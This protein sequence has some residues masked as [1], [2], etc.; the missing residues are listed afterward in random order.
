MRIFLFILC[1]LSFLAGS[2]IF[3]GA[4]SAIHEIE[5]FLLFLICAVFSVGAAI[6]DAIHSQ[7]IRVTRYLDQMFQSQQKAEE[8]LRILRYASQEQTKRE[9]SLPPPLTLDETATK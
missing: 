4:K 8:Y 5:A 2:M 3:A 7:S 9:E 1:L 6:V